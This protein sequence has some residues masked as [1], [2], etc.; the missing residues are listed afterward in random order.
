MRI[1][2]ISSGSGSRGG[3]EIFLYYLSQGLSTAGHDV[4]LWIPSHPRMDELAAKC[5]NTSHVIRGAYQNTYDYKTRSLATLFNTAVSARLA[6]EWSDLRP[7]VV[8]VNK[9]NLEDGLDLLRAARVCEVPSICTVHLTQTARYLQARASGLRDQIAKD[10]LRRYPGLFVAVQETR[11]AELDAFLGGKARTETIWNG[12]PLP[13]KSALKALRQSRRQELNLNDGDFLVLGVGRLVAQKRPLDFLDKASEL[14]SQSARTKFLWVGDGDLRPEWD[15]RIRE[16]RLE[17]VASCAGWQ[18]DV[19]SYLAAGD[20]LL[21]VAE[22]EG[23]PLAI[24][25]A[26]AAGVPCAVTQNFVSETGLFDSKTVLLAHDIQLLKRALDE[27]GRLSEIADAARRL[28]EERLSI[29]AM[30]EAYERA[31]AMARSQKTRASA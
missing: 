4:I 20:L 8:H 1:L 18:E 22:Y 16:K 26:M 12:V 30:T 29:S 31:Y 9:Q 5:A 14:A 28:V 17:S 25:E 15:A 2:L 6:R 24:V 11:R 7:D 10:A 23:L 19:L 3:G 21:H 27:P 13:D